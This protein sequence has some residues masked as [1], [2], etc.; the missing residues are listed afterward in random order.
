MATPASARILTQVLELFKAGAKIPVSA[1]EDLIAGPPLV[2]DVLIE[3]LESRAVVDESWAALWSLVI[4]GERR[5]VKAIPA[6]LACVSRGNNIVAE[7]AEFALLR[8]GPRALRPTLDYLRA[9]P[10]VAGRIHLFALLAELRVPEAIDG[11]LREFCP[12]AKDFV[13]IGWMLASS[14]DDRAIAALQAAVD[15]FGGPMPDLKEPLDAVRR[16]DDLTNPL[17]GDWRTCWHWDIEAETET[18]ADPDDEIR[19][20]FPADKEE[21]DLGLAPSTYDLT[22]PVCSSELELDIRDDSVE[23]RRESVG[24]SAGRNDPCPCGSG[25]KYKRCCG[26]K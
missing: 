25:E 3:V 21:P 7:G 19:E 5:S 22:C 2:E 9:Q 14:R 13:D 24:K 6:I 11:L 23:V 10:G 4:L 18:D 26:R 1:M 17:T 20:H 8:L 16:G 15:E 12:E